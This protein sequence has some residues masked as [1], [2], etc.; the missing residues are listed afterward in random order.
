MNK[1]K[2]ISGCGAC[3]NLDPASRPDLEDYLNPEQ[4]ALY[5]SMVGADGWC[6]NF[7]KQNRDCKIYAERPDFCRVQADTFQ[8]MFGIELEDLEDF[9]IECCHQQ[10]EDVYGNQSLEL[11]KFDRELGIITIPN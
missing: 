3:C 1:W 10:I 6:V 4:L 9:A 5:L 8:T 11:L 2:C 7:D